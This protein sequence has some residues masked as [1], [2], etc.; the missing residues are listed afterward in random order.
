M[1]LKTERQQRK[2]MKQKVF[3]KMFNKIDKPPLILTQNKRE[4]T[5]N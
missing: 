4:G 3:P 1:K 5:N 2:S